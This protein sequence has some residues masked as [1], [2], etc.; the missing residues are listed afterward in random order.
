MA[1]PLRRPAGWQDI[2]AA[3]ESLKAEV[4]H[5]ELSLMPRPR[6]PH[7]RSQAV[8]SSW[9]SAP[10][11]LGEGGPGGWWI[12][13]EP[14]IAFGPHDI[15]SPDLAGWRRS[16]LPELP[17]ERPIE[18]GPD[19]VCEVLS[20]SSARRDRLTKAD[21]YLASGVPFYW[22]IDTDLRSLE[23]LA[24]ESGR[25]VRLGAWT[26]GQRAAIPPFEAVEIDVGSLF[27]PLPESA[28]PENSPGA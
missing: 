12:V 2:L 7:G 26:D 8:L 14:D 20:P 23:A 13:I 24:A 1:E 16:R 10:F 5:G 4:I 17:Q 15:V 21:L 11:D 6:P 25:W 9:L 3:P 19:W 22:L 27:L 28:P 18:L